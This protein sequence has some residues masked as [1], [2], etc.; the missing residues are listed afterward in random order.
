[1]PRYGYPV[2]KE[3]AP[4]G[5]ELATSQTCCLDD[6]EGMEDS[7]TI[8]AVEESSQL[9]VD[10]P[11]CCPPQRVSACN[12]LLRGTQMELRYTVR[13]GLSLVSSSQPFVSR[14]N[15]HVQRATTLIHKL[16]SMHKCLTALD[17]ESDSFN[18]CETRFCNALRGNRL[19][20]FLKINF[21]TFTLHKDICSAVTTLPN[22]KELECLTECECPMN[23]CAAL[24]SLL[25]TSTQL[26]ILRI[27]KL[28]MNSTGAILFLPALLENS[29]LVELCFHSSAISEARPEHR[30]TFPNFLAE[31]KTLKKLVVGAHN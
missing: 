25:R 14:T 16:L 1:M 13:E 19:I 30:G 17:I 29:T 18:G 26:A 21:R 31:S 20:R 22:L 4:S 23:F 3:H 5:S 24:A 27:P 11:R 10:K 7:E 12:R 28:C 15:A 2:N 6:L 8:Q 9:D